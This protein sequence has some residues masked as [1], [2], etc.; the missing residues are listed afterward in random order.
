[1]ENNNKPPAYSIHAWDLNL[2]YGEFQALKNVTI[3]VK[4]GIITALIG[5][6]LRKNHAA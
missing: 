3:N 4:P 1:V 2:W 6:G 5:L